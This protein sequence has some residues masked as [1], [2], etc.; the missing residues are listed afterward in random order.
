M[1]AAPLQ[2][3]APVV[4]RPLGMHKA[5][6]IAMMAGLMALNALA[7]DIMLPA[8]P[9]MG[10]ALGVADPNHRQYIITSY[11]V[12]LA[13]AQLFFGP[14]SDR[15]GRKPP[16][17]VSLVGYA[18]VGFGCVF[19]PSFWWLVAARAAQGVFASGARVIALG[20][21][22]DAYRGRGMAEVM[23]LIM[24]VF[25]VVPILAPNIGQVVLYLGPWPWVFAVLIAVGFGMAI[26]TALRLTESLPE[27][28]RRSIDFSGLVAAYGQV[29]KTRATV[30]YTLATGLIFGGLMAFIGSA[31]QVFSEVFDRRAAFTLYFSGVAGTMMVAALL[32]SRLVKRVGMR[33]LSHAALLGFVVLNAAEAALLH[34]GGG[35]QFALFYGVLGASFFCFSFI[36]ANFNALAME[37]L[38]EIAGTAAAFLGFMSTLVAAGLGA[39][40]GQRFDGTVVP[41]VTGFAAVS[42][43][44]LVIVFITEGGRLFVEPDE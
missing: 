36:G 31:E 28:K 43:G 4:E 13:V 23:S 14:A 38:G 1:V 19:A 7:I 42:A 9:A 3:S 24:M 25:M 30:G 34:S 22:R 41:L 40:I 35:G 20:I 32:N 37:P 12:G 27:A 26:W 15:F 18:V 44:A 29:L 5:E 39:A 21:V 8:M 11:L 6:L 33:R 16:L 17:V 10:D 2:S